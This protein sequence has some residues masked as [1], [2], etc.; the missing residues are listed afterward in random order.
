MTLLRGSIR[1]ARTC[2]VIE[3]SRVLDMVYWC[4][5]QEQERRCTKL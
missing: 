1:P 5:E 2:S 3:Q 4:E